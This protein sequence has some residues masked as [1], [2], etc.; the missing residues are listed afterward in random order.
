MIKELRELREAYRD[1]SVLLERQGIKRR[2]DRIVVLAETCKAAL[3]F[4]SI[5]LRSDEL[6][7][8]HR[9]KERVQRMHPVKQAYLRAQGAYLMGRVG[10]LAQAKHLR[11]Y[12]EDH[13]FVDSNFDP[14]FEPVP[15]EQD[16]SYSN[17]TAPRPGPIE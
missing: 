6:P 14:E 17:Y 16:G 10:K 11:V 8:P 13:D 5:V 12:S 1:T 7:S 3:Q 15:F 9:D 2:V 4:A